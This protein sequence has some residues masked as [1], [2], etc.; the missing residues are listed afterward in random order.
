[1][2]ASVDNDLSVLYLPL[3]DNMSCLYLWLPTL[4]N[5]LESAAVL[6]ETYYAL[7]EMYLGKKKMAEFTCTILLFCADL[8]V[9]AQVRLVG[10]WKGG[11]FFNSG[12]FVPFSWI[13]SC[14]KK[15]YLQLYYC[16]A[17]L[18]SK[19]SSVVF[20]SPFNYFPSKHDD[21]IKW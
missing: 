7:L 6:H 3:N 10:Q 5:L 8:C 14:H 21:V 20:A 19:M 15:L 9:T 2:Q 18:I 17:Y 11:P 13:H 16:N 1:M 4:T 12:I